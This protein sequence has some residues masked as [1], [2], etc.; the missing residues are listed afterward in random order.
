GLLAIACGVLLLMHHIA[1]LGFLTLLLAVYFF[2]DGIT[3][4]AGAFELRPERGWGWV[5]FG[6]IVT[7]LLGVFIWRQWPLSGT[8]AVGT[9]AGV[10][11]L[12]GGWSMVA[13]GMAARRLP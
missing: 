12:F 4:I 10:S 7:L 8:W 9:L 13:I 2:V 11:I 3:R 1:G 5:L 6:G